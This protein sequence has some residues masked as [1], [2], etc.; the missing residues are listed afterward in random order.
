GVDV[1]VDV[2]L[3]G[4]GVD[5]IEVWLGVAVMTVGVSVGV[6][7]R[8]VTLPELDTAVNTSPRGSPMLRRSPVNSES[9]PGALAAMRKV[10]LSSGP[11]SKLPA[12]KVKP[13]LH[14]FMS[15]TKRRRGVFPAG[16]F[17]VCGRKVN[18]AL[19]LAIR[20]S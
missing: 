14:R 8:T 10:Q 7:R 6:G 15:P 1:V 17:G 12:G 5:G 16:A 2:V 18:V 4:V 3:V 9:P 13:S 11:E 19:V 20:G